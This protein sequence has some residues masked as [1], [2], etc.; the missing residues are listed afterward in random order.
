EMQTELGLAYSVAGRLREASGTLTSVLKT[1]ACPP[2]AVHLL[3]LLCARELRHDEAKKL[4]RSA[5]HLFPRDIRSRYLLAQYH[6]LEGDDQAAVSIL[7]RILDIDPAYGP[8]HLGLKR[9]ARAKQ[10]G[11]KGLGEAEAS[12][13]SAVMLVDDQRI[14]RRVLDEATSLCE[15]G[16]DV[17]VIAGAPP[18]ENPSWDEECY[19]DLRII[20]VSDLVFNVLCFEEKFRYSVPYC[21]KKVAGD[22]MREHFSRL[23]PEPAW[24]RFFQERR[25]FY[26]AASEFPA[27]VYVAHD[28][29]QLPAAAMAALDRGAYLVYDSHELFPEQSFV[30]KD[31][32]LLGAMEKH[33][34]PMADRLIVVNESMVEEMHA[35][36][37]VAPEVILNCP[38]FDPAKFPLQRTDRLRESLGIPPEMKILL[39]QGNIV[40]GIRN[41]ETV[42]EGMALLGRDDIAL[43]F[44]GPDNGGGRDLLALARE[45]NLLARTL[46]FHPSVKQSDLLT[47][48]VS[49]D[50]G[51]IPYAPVDW[52]TKYCTPNKLYEFIVAGLPIL[53]NNLPELTRFVQHQGI[54]LNLPMGRPDEFA[55]AVD[56]FFLTDLECYRK[57]LREISPR[58]VWQNHEGPEIVRMYEQMLKSP[59]RFAALPDLAAVTAELS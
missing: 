1:N 31:S 22:R 52:N 14:D 28:L 51:L 18:A 23:I 11:W 15:S 35:R 13:R 7:H 29:P 36:Y 42:I 37:G 17:T 38:S 27:S 32:P 40:S 57:R 47:Y 55:L 53:A 48:T 4:L 43:V 56:R 33:L 44:M 20:R 3:A 46:F 24:H 49:A 50:A 19:P 12:A 25:D 5:T 16:W 39:Y 26:I 21:R 9:I 6:E 10:H 41:L 30:Q 8:A 54:G 45:R 2:L 34:A 59:P 58:Y